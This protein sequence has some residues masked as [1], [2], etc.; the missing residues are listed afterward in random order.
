MAGVL[1]GKGP[2]VINPDMLVGL[3]V[4]I[5]H[6]FGVLL[7]S[8]WFAS[9]FGPLHD[10]PLAAPGFVLALIA[11]AGLAAVHRLRYSRLRLA[12]LVILLFSILIQSA[13]T[14][15]G[16]G[17]DHLLIAWPLPQA[18]VAV[19]IFSLA[20]ALGSSR[21]AIARAGIV[22]IAVVGVGLAGAEL[23]TTYLYHQSLAASGGQ[24]NFSDAIYRLAADLDRPGTPDVV[25]MDW[26]FARNLQILTQ[27]RINPSERFTYGKPED[28]I[29]RVI[30]QGLAAGPALYLFHSPKSTTYPGYLELF[31]DLAY[32][33]RL[34]PVLEKTYQQRD[35][36]PVYLVYSLRPAP[37]LLALPVGATP[38]DAQ[39]GEGIA[40]LGYDLPSTTLAPAGKLAVTLYW[41]AQAKQAHSAKVFVHLYDSSGKL[42]AQHD[43]VP[44]NWGYPT[45]AWQ[46]GEVV[47]D[48]AQLT[49]D[50]TIPPG[51][52][53]LF[54]GMYDEATGQRLPVTLTGRRVPGD[55]LGLTDITVAPSAEN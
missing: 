41:S 10:N 2:P 54:V 18:L 49:V 7:S 34:E 11:L 40:L 55:T 48:R 25:A 21:T 8:T 28:Q 23:A 27:G 37:K 52:Y 16:R 30:E 45:T 24:W 13:L 1:A 39:F 47:D 14:A 5:R 6:D 46:P 15:K 32:R 12:L 42:W 22:L 44:V 50:G 4:T 36:R 53:H 17:A 35:G 19:A 29:A 3:L 51:T 43:G 38:T 31:E 33:H 26:G 9:R 20:G